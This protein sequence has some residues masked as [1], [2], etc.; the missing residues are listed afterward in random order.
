MMTLGK[1]L[2]E[3]GYFADAR[4]AAQAAVK[5]LA[6][7]EQGFGPIAAMTGIHLVQGKVT[8]SASLIA[9]RIRRSDRYDYHI[10]RLD[11]QACTIEVV[12]DGEAIGT[13]TFTIDDA[14]RAGLE[15]GTNWRK[16]P[17][18]MLFARAIS[19]AA[20]WFCPD[21]F[22]GS[23]VYMPD[24]LGAEV[25]EEGMI[26]TAVAAPA[27][28]P[29]TPE[30]QIEELRKLM[31][32]TEADMG[33]LLAHYHVSQL[34]DLSAAQIDDAIAI[35]QSKFSKESALVEPGTQAVSSQNVP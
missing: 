13:S 8:L 2:A 31:A 16:Y 17:R 26:V 35:L 32:G 21:V 34:V 7:R 18:N 22:A 28:P 6:G 19:N 4:A 15:S 1:V 14:K 12:M 9:A 29:P 24:E 27:S 10:L 25:D 30:R 23:P 11:D 5:V 3:S 33:R 20:R